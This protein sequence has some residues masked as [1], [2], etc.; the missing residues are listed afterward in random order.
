VHGA[1][2]EPLASSNA[3]AIIPPRALNDACARLPGGGTAGHVQCPPRP[4]GMP[5]G[6]RHLPRMM[7]S[8]TH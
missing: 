7:L 6:A 2:E 5:A 4:M 1:H 8:P 3:S